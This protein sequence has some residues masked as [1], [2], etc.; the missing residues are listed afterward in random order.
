[1][2][3]IAIYITRTITTALIKCMQFTSY[4]FHS[5]INFAF[6]GDTLL[7][8]ACCYCLNK[9]FTKTWQ[10]FTGRRQ[11]TYCTTFTKVQL[12]SRPRHTTVSYSDILYL[13]TRFYTKLRPP[14]KLTTNPVCWVACYSG[15]DGVLCW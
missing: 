7:C 5:Q 8:T 15:L 9:L 6:L 3:I 14:Q 10:Q 2:Y 13:F 11:C 12:S 1:M 4:H